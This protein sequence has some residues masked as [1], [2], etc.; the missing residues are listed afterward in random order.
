MI[1]SI[2]CTYLPCRL[3]WVAKGAAWRESAW[4]IEKDG[5]CRAVD[6]VKDAFARLSSHLDQV[7]GR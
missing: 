2:Y 7:H 5:D 4:A 6:D 1:L 3:E